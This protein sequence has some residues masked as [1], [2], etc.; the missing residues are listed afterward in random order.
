MTTKREDVLQALTTALAGLSATV[1]RSE[2]LPQDLPANGLVAIR[3]G[4]VGQNGPPT[5][6]PVT[7][8]WEHVAEL[9]I[10]V[11][12]AAGEDSA[13]AEIRLDT[14]LEAVGQ[15][16]EADDTL[17]GAVDYAEAQ[18]PQTS[19][20]ATDGAP[21]IRAA[22]VPVALWYSSSNPLT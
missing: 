11:P 8:D 7:Y 6:N 14:L 20:L 21:E 2:S 17:G 1:M 5:I 22:V 19:Q 9:D 4:T 12:R 10:L 18:S 15:A 13:E 3:N 16:I